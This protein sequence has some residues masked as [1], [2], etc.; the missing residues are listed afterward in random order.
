MKL[1]S[2]KIGDLIADIPIIQGMGIGVS[3]SK[4]LLQLL[5]KAELA[6]FQEFKLVLMSLILKQIIKKLI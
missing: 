2:L 6:L 4:L 3:R 1:P 5:M